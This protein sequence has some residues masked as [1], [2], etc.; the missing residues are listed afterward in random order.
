MTRKAAVIPLLLLAACS[1]APDQAEPAAQASSGAVAAVTAAPDSAAATA[2]AAPGAV[3]IDEDGK[4]FHF[5]FAYPA[6]AAGIPALKAELDGEKDKARSALVDAAKQG[7]TDAQGG[8][9]DFNPYDRSIEW[10]VVTDLPGWLSLKAESYAFTGGAHGNSGSY[11]L[12]W[13]KVAGRRRE[14]LSLF[15]SKAAFD[16]AFGQPYCAALN[17]ERSK[18]RERKVDPASGAEFD[19][20]L[21]PSEVTV[22]LGSGDRAHFTRIGLI[23]DPYMAGSYAEGSYEVTLP[24][25]P[26]LIRAVKPEYRSLFAPGR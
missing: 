24:V 4:L 19:K 7:R 18:R 23:G 9:Y 8:G 10:S 1:K 15:V 12:V 20:C 21:A 14:P 17:A 16:A 25:T 22:L 2:A 5:A 3:K 13:D 6:A 11:A 26:A